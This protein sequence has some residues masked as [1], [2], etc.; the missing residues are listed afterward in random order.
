[1]FLRRCALTNY[2]GTDDGTGKSVEAKPGQIVE[3]SEV[4]AARLAFD[5]PGDWQE[6]TGSFNEPP[7]PDVAD[8]RKTR[9]PRD[10]MVRGAER[11]KCEGLT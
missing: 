11:T 2:H 3:V 4:M 1:M 9:P 10:R 8:T 5:F 7:K 6:V